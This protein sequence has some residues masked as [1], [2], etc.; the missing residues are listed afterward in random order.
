M[1]FFFLLF[2]FLLS[3][4]GWAKPLRE[5][6]VQLMWMDQF[7]FAGLYMAKE[8]GYYRDA[9]LQ[10][11][12]KP[13]VHGMNTT[14]QVSDGKAT[15]G[16]GYSSV[17][18]DR[19]KGHPIIALGAMFQHSPLSI[20]VT[21]SSGIKTVNDLKNKKIMVTLNHVEDASIL[22]MLTS[23][24]LNRHDFDFISH[25]YNPEDLISGKTDAMI[26]Y[27]TNEPFRILEKGVASTILNPKDYG[28]DF[29]GDIVYTTKS[30]VEN[31][32]EETA[33]FYEATMKGWKYAF[34][35]ID[36]TIEVI[37]KSY[38]SQRKSKTALRFEAEELKKLSGYGTVNFGKLNTTKLNKI[39][40]VYQVMKMIPSDLD[41]H[42]FVWHRY[43][44]SENSMSMSEEEEKYLL[45]KKQITMC[46]HPDQMPLESIHKNLYTGLG[47]EYAKYFSKTLNIP[48]VLV[49][50]HTWSET[51]EYAKTKKCDIIPL[52]EQ[53][54]DRKSYLNFTQS[55]LLYS[56][57]TDLSNASETEFRIGVRDDDLTLQRLLEK[58]LTTLSDYEKES[59]EEH[60]ISHSIDQKTDFWPYITILSAIL[61]IIAGIFIS[62]RIFIPFHI[63]TFPKNIKDPLSGLYNRRY[64]NANFERLLKELLQ[65]DRYVF[66]IL[67]NIDHFKI[68]NNRHGFHKGDTLIAEV[69]TTILN[70]SKNEEIGFR[71]SGAEFGLVG[72][73]STI[74]E[75]LLRAEQIRKK[76][77][78][79]KI[80]HRPNSPYGIVTISSGIII[81]PHD[82]LDTT[83]ESL[84]LKADIALQEAK[85]KGCNKVIRFTDE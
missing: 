39:K 65:K 11:V 80:E 60:W 5:V 21:K 26:V 20:A 43:L 4:N 14:E 62:K 27:S 33:A 23:Q 6:S 2:L 38:N 51:L 30:Q 34:E 44:A 49:P 81:I 84:Y 48:F 63:L 64:L 75:A 25:T 19:A 54:E 82:S 68:Y 73:S 28:F 12:L 72:A 17:I 37:H 9:G 67:M 61:M 52:I 57:N 66:L 58:T 85:Q 70:S 42:E 1:K 24:G 36:E 8:K 71:L 76:I 53:T 79:L 59:I 46:V 22:A 78:S 83:F 56:S 15:Y 50:T 74:E 35:H 16:I 69:G 47:A 10:V 29:Y 40:T 32:P 7:E 77:E 45:A 13:Y 18:I 55:Y 31:Y 41:I 3:T